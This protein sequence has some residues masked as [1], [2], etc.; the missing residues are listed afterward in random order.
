M[1]CIPTRFHRFDQGVVGSVL[2]D[3]RCMPSG[4][5]INHMEDDVLLH[6]QQVA[7]DLLVEGVRNFNTAGI[8]R[9][10][11]L[12]LSADRTGVDNLGN[13]LEH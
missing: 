1:L 11:F 10:L 6:E 4:A 12:P 13:E 7:L 9:T 5:A 8:R 3:N 2:D